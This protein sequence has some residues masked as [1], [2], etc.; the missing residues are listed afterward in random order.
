MATY[1]EKHKPRL[2]QWQAVRDPNKVAPFHEATGTIVVHT[3]EAPVSRGVKWAADLL[4][5]R[6]DRQASYHCLAGPDS[7][8]DVLP[9]VPWSGAAWHETHSNRWSI[10]ISMVTHA[11]AWSK[12]TAIQRDNLVASAAYAS[13]LAAAWLKQH[14]GITVPAARITRAQAMNGRPGFIGHGEMDPGRRSDPGAGFPWQKFLTTY[15]ALM[16]GTDNEGGPLVATDA[17]IAKIAY[18]VNAYKNERQD[19]RDVYGMILDLT[20]AL[21]R[22]PKDV[23]LYKNPKVTDRDA[24]SHLLGASV[25]QIRE[26]V[27]DVV[28]DLP[29]V[30]ASALADQIAERVVLIEAAD[31]AEQLTVNVKGD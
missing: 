22:L 4:V 17:E 9:L 20:R 28:K 13:Y 6:T 10:G 2:H 11:D 16:A 23:W 21:E 25:E 30:D 19:P 5:G 14:R 12:I 7:P 3:F 8:R 26:I 27:A 1:F 24:Y 15:A 31:V 29:G 18:A